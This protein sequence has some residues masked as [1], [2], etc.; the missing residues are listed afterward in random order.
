MKRIF[1]L[2]LM[3][4]LACYLL[5]TFIVYNNEEGR[6]ICNELK[7]NITNEDEYQFIQKEEIERIIRQASLNPIGK[8]MKEINTD[9]IEA[10]LLK[11]QLIAEAQCYKT[12]GGMVTLQGDS[13]QTLAGAIRIDITQRVPILRV[14]GTEGNFYIDNKGNY[15][16]TS[17]HFTLYLPVVTGYA[18]KEF[19]Q[20]ELF[21]FARFLQEDKFW[22]AQIEQIHVR[23]DKEIELI[24]RVGSHLILLGKLDNFEQK[25]DNLML[26]YQQVF[27]QV[28]WNK[29]EAINLKYKNQVIATRK[30]E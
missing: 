16:P 24:P 17:R 21:P 8:E 7:I 5:A 30:G 12:P 1:Q 10:A 9:E 6:K 28:G 4:I 14:I 25:L 20:K 27:P 29:Y 18:D 11:N 15:M 23:A 19:V 2:I 13:T 26:M 22:N 3:G